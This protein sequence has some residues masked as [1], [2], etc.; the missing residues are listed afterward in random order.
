CAPAIATLRATMRL[1]GNTE[2]TALLLGETG[3]GKE[4]VARGLHSLSDRNGQFVAV[5]CGAI[6]ETLAERHLFGHAKG[7]FKGANEDHPGYFRMAK[8]GT[9]FLDEVG[10]LSP[11]LQP[12]LLRVLDTQEV[13][14]VGATSPTRVDV[15]VIAAT[16]REL[17][18]EVRAGGF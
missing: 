4:D 18:E 8:G 15:R 16:N 3:V 6:P 1:V 10:E 7:S 12:K 2:S 17:L 5:N 11:P 14:S 9:L 13:Y